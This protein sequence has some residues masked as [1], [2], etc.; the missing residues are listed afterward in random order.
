MEPY[1][2][3][4]RV[5]FTLLRTIASRTVRSYRT[6]SPLPFLAEAKM[7]VSSLLHLS[8]VHTAQA[9][10]GTLLF[11]ARTFLPVPKYAATVWPTR[12]GL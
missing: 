4:L 3:L 7:A 11:E 12:R 6:L 9:L 10:P 1:L 2:V 5:E 8:S